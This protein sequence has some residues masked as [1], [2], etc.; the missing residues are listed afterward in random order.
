MAAKIDAV[1]ASWFGHK[2]TSFLFHYKGMREADVASILEFSI[3]F[4]W[5]MRLYH[6]SEEIGGFRVI[7]SGKN[8]YYCGTRDP[9]PTRGRT[10]DA[11]PYGVRRDCRFREG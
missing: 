10:S 3:L 11:R 1:L 8:D 9:A 4:R 6:F 2:I 5:S 7:N